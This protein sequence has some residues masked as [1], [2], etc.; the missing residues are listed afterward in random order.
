MPCL[1]FVLF[2]RFESNQRGRIRSRRG[3]DYSSGKIAD[4]T[5]T[6]HKHIYTQKQFRESA[7]GCYICLY[8]ELCWEAHFLKQGI[9]RAFIYRKKRGSLHSIYK[10]TVLRVS[11][12][13][14]LRN[15]VTAIDATES[16]RKL[17][18]YPIR[19]C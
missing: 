17:F 16:I 13:S 6:H 19:I 2:I 5:N 9:C 12:S 3:P 10:Q 18:F 14:S 7:C 4:Q 11:Y 15:R 8:V 1:C